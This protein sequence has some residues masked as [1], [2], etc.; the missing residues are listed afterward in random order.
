MI[1]MDMISR[2][3]PREMYLGKLDE[4]AG[5]NEIV[6]SVALSFGIYLDPEGMDKYIN[7]SDQA[8]FINKG[9]PAVFLYGENHPEFHTERDDIALT[10]PRKI[11]AISR[12]MVLCV[13]MCANHNGSF[14]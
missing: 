2:N 6:E 4:F 10:N 11:D 13:W 1:N 3:E 5:L 7:R 9:I 12:L 8:S 14:R